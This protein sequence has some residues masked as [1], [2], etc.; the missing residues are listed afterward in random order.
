MPLKQRFDRL[1]LGAALLQTAV[2]LALLA[3]ASWVVASQRYH[4]AS[5]HFVLWQGVT[6]LV[7]LA[8]LVMAMH[9]RLNLLADRRLVWAAMAV[10]LALLV[11][12]LAQPPLNGTW[13]WARIAGVS[14]QPSV[15]ARLALLLVAAVELDAARRSA[16]SLRSLLPLA[17][18]AG[19]TVVLVVLGSDLGSAA[20]ILLV[21][22]SMAFVAGVPLRVL[23]AP[24]AAAAVGLVGA[25]VS[26]PYRVRRVMAFFDP[27]QAADASWQ[28]YQS[29]IA[30]GS[31]GLFGR[32]YGEGLQKLLFLP[33]PHT[34]FIFAITGEELGLVGLLGV[35]ALVAIV[36]WRGLRVA[37]RHAEPARAL[38]A[39]GL[40]ATFAFQ[41]VIH[42]AVCLDLLPAKGIPLPL[43]SYGKTDLVAAMVGVGLLL[44]LS[45]EVSQ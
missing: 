25:V 6:A 10:A 14:F 23:M 43:I 24:A 29:L 35:L 33:E 18:A 9:L 38:L 45:R 15:V 16:W 17:G 3:S 20:L 27:D 5:S 8:L 39:F 2:G 37:A 21:V 42:M 26:S 40:T 28:T 1:L 22:A 36:T 31:G 44:N 41:A 32:G 34:D 11:V 12:P 13:R 7:G 4:R 30:L 19:A